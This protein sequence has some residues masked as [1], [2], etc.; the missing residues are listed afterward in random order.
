MLT[1]DAIRLGI[2]PSCKK[3]KTIEPID[4]FKDSTEIESKVIKKPKMTE[5]RK[6]ADELGITVPFGTKKD[7]LI[8]MINEKETN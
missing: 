1:A 5:L 2:H 3:N 6:K 4:S 8:E 7:E